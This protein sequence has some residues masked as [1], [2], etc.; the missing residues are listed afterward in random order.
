MLQRSKSL[1]KSF[2]RL[3]SER[4]V[5]PMS[6]PPSRLPGQPSENPAT[7][8][9]PIEGSPTKHQPPRI[10]TPQMLSADALVAAFGSQH[11]WMTGVEFVGLAELFNRWDKDKS[12]LIDIDEF[13]PMLQEVVADVFAFFDLDGSGYLDKREVGR[14]ARFLGQDMTAQELEEAMSLMRYSEG[15]THVDA[16]S[17]DGMISCKEFMQWWNT[18]KGDFT[19]AELADLLTHVDT[20]HSGALDVHEFIDAISGKM[21]ARP[22]TGLHRSPSIMISYALEAAR[23]DIKAIYGSSFRP[24][25]R[26]QRMAD[27]EVELVKRRCFFRPDGLVGLSGN[28]FQTNASKFKRVWD[29][30]L[31]LILV[32]VAVTVPYRWGFNMHVSPFSSPWTFSWDVAVDLCFITDIFIN[33]RTGI[34]DEDGEVIS[35]APAIAVNYAK[36]WM[37]IDIGGCLPISYIMLISDGASDSG[38]ISESARGEMTKGLKVIRLLR[39]GKMLRLAKFRQLM[40]VLDTVYP[41]LWTT[42]KLFAIIMVIMFLSHVV[43]CGW[44]QIGHTDQLVMT[45]DGEYAVSVPGWVTGQFLPTYGCGSGGCGSFHDN[46]IGFDE[47]GTT[48]TT[49]IENSI[50]GYSTEEFFN[51][52]HA[53][54][55]AYYYAITTLTTVGYGDRTPNTDLEKVYSILTEL[56]GG[57]V[58]GVLTSSLG[59]M[60]LEAGERQHAIDVELDQLGDFMIMKHVP[61]EVRLD[62]MSQMSGFFK[63]KG[64]FNEEHIMSQLPNKFR[65]QLLLSMYKPQIIH[66]PLFAGMPDAVITTIAMLMQ[67]YLAI[68]DDV[69]FVENEVGKC[70]QYL[71]STDLLHKIGSLKH[72][73]FESALSSQGTTCSW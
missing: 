21:E 43:A 62:L 64:L 13:S 61:K 25:N 45:S 35:K 37:F 50:D 30:L 60:M 58:F 59:A 47:N 69:I 54:I 1:K 28:D 31:V 34:M 20:D 3:H 57:I 51:W 33:L 38:N 7:T 23:S 15:H 36:S 53:Y 63:S 49:G 73:L 55:D 17:S 39:L 22:K 72:F 68:K 29:I 66:C 9:A 67:P 11:P 6:Q 24:M 27:V 32:Y 41:G 2:Q 65:K 14:L 4:R 16:G 5:A 42:S 48:G 40:K 18:W 70:P 46:G 44:Y 19:E 52:H 8:A 10:L 26:L 56:A 71:W 12:G